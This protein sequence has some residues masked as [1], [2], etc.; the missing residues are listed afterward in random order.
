MKPAILNA[1][2]IDVD[3][4]AQKQFET[5]VKN[6]FDKTIVA[7]SFDEALKLYQSI[8]PQ[9]VF[10]NFSINQRRFQFD[11]ISRLINIPDVNPLFLGYCDIIGPE[12]LTHALENGVQDLF[13][14]PYDADLISSKINKYYQTDKTINRDLSYTVLRPP[15]EVQVRLKFKLD[16][17]DE[18]GLTFRGNHY[19]SKGSVIPISVPLIQEIF[20]TS[21]MD[22]IV[23]K[24][25]VAEDWSNYFFYAE[26][27]E[28]KD[29]L[30]ASLRK[31]IL[32]K[33]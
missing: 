28:G 1:L 27:K 30:S 26:P 17:V 6:L 3:K 2:I 31:F 29:H 10:F 5:E 23:T 16:S 19:V 4:D 14:R 32:G 7:S 8:K 13:A 15:L 25:W 22:F 18:S 24:T 12:L 11:L 21:S 9:V 20:N 33:I